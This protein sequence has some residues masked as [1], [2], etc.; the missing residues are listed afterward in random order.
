MNYINKKSKKKFYFGITSNGTLF[1]NNLVKYLNENNF[2]ITVSLD[3]PKKIHDRYRR[4]SSGKGTYDI[5]INNL[6]KFY[7]F[8]RKTYASPSIK[9]NITISPPYKLNDIKEYFDSI[10][11]KNGFLI[12]KN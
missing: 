9:F 7:H 1:N 11:K 12:M 5:I 3:G 8:N 2:L 6:E 4:L 10:C